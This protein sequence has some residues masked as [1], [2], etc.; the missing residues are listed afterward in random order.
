MRL[1][2]EERKML[3]GEFGESSAKAMEVL[4]KLGEVYGAEMMTKISSAHISDFIHETIG[5]PGLSFVE[6]LARKGSKVRVF[7]TT[8]VGGFD[9][10]SWKEFGIS[11]EGY[12]SKE[13]R[14]LQALEKIGCA[15]TCSCT[16]YY[17]SNLPRFH[18][19]VAWSESSTVP[20]VNSVL[21]ARS[22]RE[23]GLSALMAALTGRTPLYSYHLEEN[24]KGKVLVEVEKALN[25][26]HD[27]GILGYHLGGILVDRV[28]VFSGLSQETLTEDLVELGAGLG[29]SGAVGM[30]HI[31]RVTAESETEEEAFGGERP[32]EKVEVG[33]EEFQATY[34]KLNAGQGK[35][36]L[37]AIG[38][39][40]YS[41]RQVGRAAVLLRG[42]TVKNGVRLW[43]QT[44]AAVHPLAAYAGYLDIIKKAG[45]II[46][47]DTCASAL[48][49]L[50]RRRL[51]KLTIATDSAKQAFYL[52]AGRGWH[53][54][55]LGSTEQCI[56]AAVEGIWEE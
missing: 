15:T 53:D 10:Q 37:V 21:G 52:G 50:L 32:L 9:R 38:C 6:D 36:D 55:L 19:N 43:V 12:V 31:P 49:P 3:D 20:F 17:L 34:S 33:E 46:T 18:Q 47:V 44:C 54:T 28:P 25:G 1:Q 29:T 7:T 23:S 42:K 11:D 41:L 26:T 16:P 56:Q 45:G 5:D 35:V 22:S 39:P 24:R 27:F 4:V 30:Y 40:H 2:E 13:S 8:N 14:I 48:G 51:G